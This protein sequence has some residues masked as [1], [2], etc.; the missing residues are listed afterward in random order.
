MRTDRGTSRARAGAVAVALVALAAAFGWHRSHPT[1]FG[2]KAY[3][4]ARAPAP[5]SL[6]SAAMTDIAVPRARGSITGRVTFAGSSRAAAGVSVCALASS[7]RLVTV[8]ER[9][10]TC[11]STNGDGT[12]RIVDL[13]AARYEVTASQARLAPM[14]F[15]DGRGRSGLELEPGEARER[16]DIALGPEGVEVRGRVKDITGGVVAGALLRVTSGE[17]N[18]RD[19]GEAIAESN[20]DGE[21]SV[22]VGPGSV[23]ATAAAGG[24]ASGTKSATAPGGTVE[25]VLVPESVLQGRV[26]EAGTETPVAAARVE[27]GDGS[28][29]TDAEGRF[30]IAGL[31]PGRYKPIAKTAH[32]WGT[33]RESVLLGLAET[34]SELVV[35]VF[36]AATVSGRVLFPDGAGCESPSVVLAQRGAR[37]AD[38]SSSEADGSVRIESLMPG[39]YSVDV[40]CLDGLRETKYP[41][42][43][44]ADQ[45]ISGVVWKVR[46]GLRASGTVVDGAGAPVTFATVSARSKPG[47]DPQAPPRGYW[48]TAT[49]DGMGAFVLRGMGPASYE[50]DV[51]REGTTYLAESVELKVERDVENVRVVLPAGGTIEGTLVDS[52]GVAVSGV[53]VEADSKRQSRGR[54]SR[55]DGTFAITALSPGEYKVR[56]EHR[57]APGTRDDDPQGTTVRVKAGEATRVKLV[58]ESERGEIHGRVIG[59][60]GE[61]ITDAFLQAEREP[62]HAGAS[63]GTA[64]RRLH[65]WSGTSVLTDVDGKFSLTKLSP[66]SYSV[67]AFRRGGGEA[68]LE[69]VELGTHVTLTIKPE[70]SLSGSVVGE[71]GKPPERFSVAVRDDRSGVSREESYF[72]TDGKWVLRNL[73]D[74]NFHV[75][76]AAESGRA[77]TDL[78][79]AQGENRDGIVLTL[80]PGAVVRGRVV[81]LDDGKPLAGMTVYVRPEQNGATFAPPPDEDR[82][83][84]TDAEGRFEA[85]GPAGKVRVTVFPKGFG[86]GHAE[87]MRAYVPAQ[88]GAGQVTE[89]PDIRAARLRLASGAEP[90]ELGVSLREAAPGEELEAR[91]LVVSAIRPAS[92]AAKTELAAGDEIV[93]VDGTD[94]IG[95]NAYLFQGLTRVSEGT[96][97]TLGLRRGASIAIKAG[98]AP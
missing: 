30:R 1:R 69:K 26:V 40:S 66:G 33:A 67:R 96:S 27:A 16:V 46:R 38:R 21:W 19:G 81:A 70:G 24:Y 74:G 88:L 94:V 32:G 20:R 52:A 85:R 59:A 42:I 53:N 68:L 8:E 80:M 50:I 82:K 17:E 87:F 49:T 15:H 41:A 23:R 9:T 25:I 45:D 6:A 62:D 22:W 58:I 48:V 7:P 63:Q 51:S 76:A 34:S 65:W 14:S 56:A 73:P 64:R 83:F 75:T 89:V 60:Q 4:A 29:L 92:S 54:R 18:G 44:V 98:R 39:E 90:G 95:P 86:S 10:P 77:L 2:A 28:V 71:G 97:V 61:A 13:L 35:E 37:D 47:S 91:R 84:V 79:L 43:T 12:Y 93:S 3:G 5:A 57:R 11:V 78:P 55:D 36:R 31:G 72:R